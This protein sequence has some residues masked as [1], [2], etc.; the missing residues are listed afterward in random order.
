MGI[1]PLWVFV[2]VPFLV[3]DPWGQRLLYLEDFDP[4]P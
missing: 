1:E 4:K 2:D 3:G